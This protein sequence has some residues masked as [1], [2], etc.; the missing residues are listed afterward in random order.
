MVKVIDNEIYKK[1]IDEVVNLVLPWEKLKNKTVLISGGTGLIGTV[2]IDTLMKR[3]YVFNDNINVICISRNE[4]SIRERFYSYYQDSNFTFFAY[5]I[6]N[7]LNFNINNVDYIIHAASNTHP[8]L[9]SSDPIGTITTNVIGTKNLLDFGVTHNL[10]RFLFLSSVEIYGE[11]KGDVEKFNEGY[12]GYLDCNTL[13]AG[14]PESKRVG[15]TLCK[16][17]EHKYGIETVTARLSRIY[18]PTMKNDDSKVI[19]Q[20]INNAINGENIVL[21]SDGSQRYSFN[22]VID[23]VS[24]IFTILLCGENGKVYNIADEKSDITL[25]ELAELI[26]NMYSLDVEFSTPSKLEKIGFSKATTAVMDSN[27]LKKLGWKA[28]NPIKVGVEKTVNIL[29]HELS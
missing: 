2:I 5:D 28:M 14:Y 17:Y 22:Y 4:D 20:F 15:E 25:K 29:K 23:A 10:K 21:K 13:R 7:P 19:M 3:N 16:A 1:D 6:N 8:L 26:G 12:L 27:E 11:N 9:Y 18:G 24:A